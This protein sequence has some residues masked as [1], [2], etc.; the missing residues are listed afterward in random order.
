MKYF[1]LIFGILI[2]VD[3]TYFA[4][5]N[6]GQTLALNYKPLIDT[7][8]MNSGLLYF[9]LGIYGVVGGVFLTYSRILFL[10]TQIK[11]LS[12]KSEKASVE[13]EESSDKVKALEAK[14]QTL[15]AA[16]KDCLNKK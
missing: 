7:F 10:K 1:L 6:Q 15:E 12:R 13:S 11:T 9:L 3:I 5:V 16:L 8:T 4:F 14:I 2:V